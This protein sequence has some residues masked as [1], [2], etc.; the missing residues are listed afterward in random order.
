M[1]KVVIRLDSIAKVRGFVEIVSR[2]NGEF[3]LSEGKYTVNGKSI[4]G[5]CTLN[6]NNSLRLS[7][8]SVD[9][10]SGLIRDLEPYTAT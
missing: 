4:M 7:I 10:L 9:N 2:Y 1:E 8:E 5:I 3:T 6:L